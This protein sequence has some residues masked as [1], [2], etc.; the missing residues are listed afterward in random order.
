MMVFIVFFV[1]ILFGGF[2]KVMDVYLFLGGVV[3]FMLFKKSGLFGVKF[4]RMEIML[5]EINVGVVIFVIFF[6]L[7]FYFF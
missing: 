3:F 1:G 4:L 6:F 5:K 2:L 7:L